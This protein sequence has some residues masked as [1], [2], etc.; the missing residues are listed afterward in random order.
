MDEALA[1][2][3]ENRIAEQKREL[4]GRTDVKNN[5]KASKDQA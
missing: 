3:V 2:W 4:Y 5:L 1:K